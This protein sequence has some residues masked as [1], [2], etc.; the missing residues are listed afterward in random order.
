[1]P[2][3]TPTRASAPASTRS[4]YRGGAGMRRMEEEFVKQE[5]AKEARKN[6]TNEPF[7]F[8]CKVGETREIVIIDDEPD[9]FRSEHALMNPASKRYNLFTPC[10]D[11]NANCPVCAISEK[12][13]YFAMY[14]TVIDLTPYE[15]KDGDVVDWSK[16]MLVVKPAQQKKIARL[17]EKHKTLRGMVLTM[18][19]DDDKSAAIGNDIEF[20]EFM[21]EDELEDYVTEYT[22]K[23]K[24]VHEVIGNEVFNYEEIYPE[25]TEKQLTAMAGGKPVRDDEPTS[26]RSSRRSSSR[27]E[28]PAR[29]ARSAS[30]RGR[31]DDT[32]EEEEA[33]PARRSARAARE[34][35]APRTASRRGARTVDE[36]E[37]EEAPPARRS[38]RASR[39]KDDDEE[40]PP[41]RTSSRRASREVEEEEEEP[42]FDEPTR[43]TGASSRREQIRGTRR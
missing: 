32:E 36:E 19:R 15:N 5:A 39:A 22:D 8:F 31:D 34:E 13:A 14:L 42:P 12:P 27:D 6:Q 33:P 24:K 3:R 38:A 40:D 29:T 25:L 7:R 2:P 9:F 43:R 41:Q 17:L 11:E 37:E 30:R 4:N 26:S 28:E 1:M 35:P 10:I 20:I 21:S 23:E 18:T 16:K